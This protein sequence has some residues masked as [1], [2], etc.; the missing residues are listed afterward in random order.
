MTCEGEIPKSP[1]VPTKSPISKPDDSEDE[2]NAKLF[3][4]ISS[5]RVLFNFIPRHDHAEID[6]PILPL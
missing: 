1:V 4:G 5:S 3:D 2:V 6:W